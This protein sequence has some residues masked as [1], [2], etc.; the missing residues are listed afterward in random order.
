MTPSPSGRF[1]TGVILAVWFGSYIAAR[2]IIPGLPADSWLRT[3]VA[4]LPLLPT[5][6]VLWRISAAIR[7][8]D[9]LQ[10][11]VHLEALGMAFALAMVTLWTLGLLE[12]AIELN[13]EDWSYRHVWAM[14]P[15]FYFIGLA[16]AWRR[17]K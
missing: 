16:F 3:A 10:R 2:A 15:L 9:E 4:L 5:I 17:Y 7:G 1:L 8:L 14:L 12:L 13:R 6:A 11:R